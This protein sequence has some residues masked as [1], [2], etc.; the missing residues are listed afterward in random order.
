MCDHTFFFQY[1]NVVPGKTEEA[2]FA[3]LF[4]CLERLHRPAWREDFVDVGLVFDGV[5]LL[6]IDVIGLEKA[7]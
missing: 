4:R 2:A 3:G 7:E 5:Q 1:S 6:A